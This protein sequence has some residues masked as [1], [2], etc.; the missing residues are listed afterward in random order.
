LASDINNCVN[1]DVGAVPTCPRVKLIPLTLSLLLD[2]ARAKKSYIG[3]RS[4]LRLTNSPD[5]FSSS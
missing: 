2:F 3:L 1:F 5:N 4:S